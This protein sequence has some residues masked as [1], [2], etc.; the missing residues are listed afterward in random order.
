MYAQIKLTITRL[1]AVYLL[2]LTQAYADD[3]KACFEEWPPYTTQLADGSVKGISI[4]ALEAALKPYG[5]TISYSVMPY[6]RC[7]AEAAAGKMDIAFFVT[8]ENVKNMQQNSVNMAWWILGVFVPADSNQQ[9]YTGLQ[10]FNGKSIGTVIGYEYTEEIDSFTGWRKQPIADADANL[11]KLNAHRIDL[12]IDD[13]PW[14]L[15]TIQDKKLNI[16]LLQPVVASLPNYIVFSD[17]LKKQIPEIDKVLTE[18]ETDGRLDALYKKYTGKSY[19]DI[20]TL[21]N[22]AVTK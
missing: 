7:E 15:Q 22:S 18:M 17:K 10:A 16:R 3:L 19:S 20:N 5:H 1:A 9:A 8:P 14:V 4:E 2:L 6:A 21:A 12:V 11:K 13:V